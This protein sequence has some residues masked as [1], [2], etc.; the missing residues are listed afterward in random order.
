MY[1]VFSKSG[2]ELLGL[3][4]ELMQ[5]EL[6]LCISP[7]ALAQ[8]TLKQTPLCTTCSDLITA[9]VWLACLFCRRV[10]GSMEEN[11]DNTRGVNHG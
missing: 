6:I 7:S 2:A 8:F 11:S 9:P 3:W 5:M 10:F 1:S 4:A